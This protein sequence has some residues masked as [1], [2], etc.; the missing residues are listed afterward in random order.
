MSFKYNYVLEEEIIY[1]IKVLNAGK[2][3]HNK[4]NLLDN[5]SSENQKEL[6]T[7]ELNNKEQEEI[8]ILI[9]K[10][11]LENSNKDEFYFS[12]EYYLNKLKINKGKIILIYF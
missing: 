6:D 9:N 11:K 4:L 2:Y 8:L 5:S 1:S 3:Q 7:F 12:M 10:L